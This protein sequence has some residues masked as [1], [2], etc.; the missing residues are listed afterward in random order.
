MFFNQYITIKIIYFM[1]RKYLSKFSPIKLYKKHIM[2]EIKALTT[3]VQIL[4][5]ILGNKESG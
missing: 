4:F 1:F 2:E 3:K 5:L